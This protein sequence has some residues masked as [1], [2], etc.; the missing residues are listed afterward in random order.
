MNRFYQD[1]V[2]EKSWQILKTL[3]KRIDFVLIGGWAVYLY[4]KGLKSKDIDFIIDYDQLEK[5]KS[6]Y[7]VYKN[8][9]LRKYEIKKEG[10]DIDIYLPHFS[11]LGLPI[12][13]IIQLQDKIETFALPKK[14]MLLI[15]K[16][17]AYQARKASLKGQ[18]DMIDMVGLMTL[19]D[20]NFYFYKKILQEN[21]LNHYVDIISDLINET[22]EMTE[23]G[24]NRHYFA[25][26]KKEILVK[27]RA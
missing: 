8:E 14:E 2:V 22:K 7:D 21:H 11:H 5:L 25:K 10:I 3:K 12:I 18:K 15:T 6:D 27:L 16:Q 4:T 19:D 9:R 1:I 23:L 26:K 13:E 17:T 24:L 20:F